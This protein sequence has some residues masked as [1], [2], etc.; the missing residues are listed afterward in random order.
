MEIV[1][2]LSINA[3]LITNQMIK[4]K[5]ELAIIE[6]KF[7]HLFNNRVLHTELLNVSI[8]ICIRTAAIHTDITGFHN[9]AS[10][11]VNTNLQ[12]IVYKDLFINTSESFAIPF[13]GER[14]TWV[15]IDL[16]L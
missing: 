15:C 8:F 3:V 10:L 12:C 16:C 14:V 13:D 1:T 6:C 4:L 11:V 5:I 7:L 9:G 2:A